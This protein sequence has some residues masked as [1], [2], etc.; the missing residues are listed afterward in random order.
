MFR[1]NRGEVLVACQ[2]GMT[3]AATALADAALG[4]AYAEEGLSTAQA[5]WKGHGWRPEA[6]IVVLGKN[7]WG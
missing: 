1:E 7:Q 3:H 2:L 5:N 6:K 4:T